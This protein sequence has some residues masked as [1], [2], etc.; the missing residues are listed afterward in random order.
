MINYAI[1]AV[2]TANK[3]MENHYDTNEIDSDWIKETFWRKDLGC[4]DDRE[5]WGYV[6]LIYHN[7]NDFNKAWKRRNE[8]TMENILK[9]AIHMF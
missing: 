6:E 2:K 3:W 7:K 9:T 1:E 4:L 8:M 5:M